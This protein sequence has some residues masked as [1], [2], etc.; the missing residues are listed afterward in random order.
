MAQGMSVDVVKSM[1]QISKDMG[2]PWNLSLW[3]HPMN[4]WTDTQAM[5]SALT[6]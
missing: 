2:Y 1:Q 4:N 5:A 6:Q 3:Y